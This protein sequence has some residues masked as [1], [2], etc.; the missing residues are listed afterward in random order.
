MEKEIVNRNSN[1][2]QFLSGKFTIQEIES[3]LNARH[4][5]RSP[6]S[7]DEAIYMSCLIDQF[8][9]A[10]FLFF[11]GKYRLDTKKMNHTEITQTQVLIPFWEKNFE[12]WIE[13]LF[14]TNFSVMIHLGTNFSGKTIMAPTSYQE[15]KQATYKKLSSLF[16]YRKD[17]T[18]KR[19]GCPEVYYPSN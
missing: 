17:K 13:P 12:V 9:E 11:K 7:L 18:K 1:L 14:Y 15:M 5:F 6:A 16:F 2:S 4:R 3:V 10:V 8:Y 19:V